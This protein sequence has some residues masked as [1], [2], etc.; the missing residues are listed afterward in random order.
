MSYVD[1]EKIIKG[2]ELQF[3]DDT[4]QETGVVISDEGYFIHT[5]SQI[6]R[7]PKY[8]EEKN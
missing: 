7:Q 4:Y 5:R 8:N 2:L 6:N 1:P 3:S